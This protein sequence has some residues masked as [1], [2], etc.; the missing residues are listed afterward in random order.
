MRVRNC[1]L[2]TLPT[3]VKGLFRLIFKFLARELVFFTPIRL[4]YR[5]FS[6]A[7]L[8]VSIEGS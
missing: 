7:R 1:D 6:I 8:H 3:S 4:E 2:T 5:D